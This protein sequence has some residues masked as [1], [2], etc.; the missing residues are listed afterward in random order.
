[1]ILKIEIK[2]PNLVIA[3][4]II[5]RS[6]GPCCLNGKW[7]AQVDI[8]KSRIDPKKW[9]R[10]NS[11]CIYNTKEEAIFYTSHMK[12]YYSDFKEELK[13]LRI[14]LNDATKLDDLSEMQSISDEIAMLDTKPK[15]D[16]SKEM[17]VTEEWAKI[18]NWID[19]QRQ[20]HLPLISTAAITS[21]NGAMDENN[22][23]H[24]S[25]VEDLDDGDHDSELDWTDEEDERKIMVIKKP[26]REYATSSKRKY[27][28]IFKER[29]DKEFHE[30]AP[31]QPDENIHE[32]LE[33][34]YTTRYSNRGETFY[35]TLI[36]G[37]L[38]EAFEDCDQGVQIQQASL[39]VEKGFTR[40][41]LSEFTNRHIPVRLFR[42][43][44]YH[45]R[46]YGAG[47][48]V[49]ADEGYHPRNIDRKVQIVKQFVI[50]L[51][52]EGH[53][54]AE[55]VSKIFSDERKVSLPKVKLLGF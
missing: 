49:P 24:S 9:I 44:N 12:W 8:K 16:W 26:L 55:A 34:C 18:S 25:D 13:K 5:V 37:A 32:T 52:K 20:V 19:R 42:R 7:R 21:P 31:G 1:M 11:G 2:T 53:R 54:T 14:E 48:V 29:I 43:I 40:E 33:I 4:S 10:K 36:K 27:S 41:D 22:E 35:E 45:R 17:P 47:K 15:I 38:E 3:M 23:G 46:M 28:K 30:F 39:L 50:F 51:L 6:L